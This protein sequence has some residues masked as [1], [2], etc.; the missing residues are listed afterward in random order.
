[1]RDQARGGGV[2]GRKV[3]ETKLAGTAGTITGATS[4]DAA[5]RVASG[6]SMAC[7]QRHNMHGPQQSSASEQRQVADSNREN[8]SSAPTKRLINA[9]I[10][11]P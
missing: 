11:L 4:G 10:G 3:R 1:M 9:R 2:G 7:V 6:D 8:R 5:A